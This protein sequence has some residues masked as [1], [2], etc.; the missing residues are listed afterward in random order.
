MITS[1]DIGKEC[2]VQVEDADTGK[3]TWERHGIRLFRGPYEN[4]GTVILRLPN[5][6]LVAQNSKFVR[7]LE[8]R[9]I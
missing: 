6:R 5:G 1:S 4:E 7:I 8:P 9:P 2:L 3:V